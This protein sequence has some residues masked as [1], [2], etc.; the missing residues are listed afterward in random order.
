[1]YLD[2]GNDRAAFNPGNGNGFSV[3]EVIFAA[4]RVYM[5]ARYADIP[6]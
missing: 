3:K 6:N 4:E 5:A 2:A 1:M